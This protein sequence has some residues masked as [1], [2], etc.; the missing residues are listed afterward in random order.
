MHP[1][2]TNLN[3]HYIKNTECIDQIWIYTTN[4]IFHVN[5]RFWPSGIKVD[6]FLNTPQ[7]KIKQQ[8]VGVTVIPA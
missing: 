2:M 7:P 1:S 3:V 8:S 5:I 4:V 6:K